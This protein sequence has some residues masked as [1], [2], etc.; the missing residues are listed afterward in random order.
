MISRRSFLRGL[1]AAPVLSVAAA[2]AAPQIGI[3]GEIGP[4]VDGSGSPWISEASDDAY[5]AEL[6]NDPEA[7]GSVWF[8]DID[9]LIAY[10]DS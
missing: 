1:C 9:D 3:M 7:R 4:E 10:L 2:A 6:D 8:D 5:I